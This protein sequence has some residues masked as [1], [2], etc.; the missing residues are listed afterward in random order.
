MSRPRGMR[1]PFVLLGLMTMASFGGPF[2]IVATIRGGT[3]PDWPP[4]RPIEWWAFGL[5]TGLVA[6]LM[7]ACLALGLGRRR[8]AD[9]RAKSGGAAG[10]DEVDSRSA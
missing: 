6:V 8:T 9:A 5:I 2:A 3:S 7:S 4:D 1:A 10:S